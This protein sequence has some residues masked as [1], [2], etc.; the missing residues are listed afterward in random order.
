MRMSVFRTLSS[1]QILEEKYN[2]GASIKEL[3]QVFGCSDFP[4]HNELRRGAIGYV[5]RRPVYSAQKGQDAYE[6]SV[7]KFA[8]ARLE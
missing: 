5:G 2:S 1:R 6:T 8:A 4:I 7:M 3:M